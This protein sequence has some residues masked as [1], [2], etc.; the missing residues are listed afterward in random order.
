MATSVTQSLFGMTPQ[1]IQAQRAAELNQQAMQF[2][3]LSPMQQAQMGMFRAGSQLGT[4]V[5]GAMGYED[6]EIAQ[7]R[8]AQGLLGG[9]DMGDPEA[10]R[11]AARNTNDPRVKAFLVDRAL[12][13]EKTQADIGRLNALAQGGGKTGVGTGPERM[14]K[15]IADVDARLAEGKPVSDL[16]LRT[17]DNFRTV[18]SSVKTYQLTD[19]TIIRIPIK[20]FSA[21]Q[22]AEAEGA[23]EIPSG[24]APQA[25]Q[26]GQ[27]Q[28]R[29]STQATGGAQVIETPVS[30]QA[31]TKELTGL[32]NNID[33]IQSDLTNIDEAIGMVNAFST[34]PIGAVLSLGPTDAR[35]LR[36]LVEGIDAAKVFNELQKL[37]DGAAS[38]A[39][40]LGQVTEREISLLMNRL[41]VLDPNGRQEDLIKD[42]QYISDSWKSIQDRIKG[43]LEGKQPA[44]PASASPA[45]RT[46][47]QQASSVDNAS[48]IDR[49]MAD[50]RNAGKSRA[51]VEAAL[52]KRGLIK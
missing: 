18:L 42:L 5:A 47:P 3:Q 22:Q 4:G 13:I 34:G 32:Q 51:Q 17:A 30:I 27:P 35:R 29:P 11:E 41:R 6:P 31:K 40:G 44:R 33:T 36:R 48:V 21:Q 24:V 50:P 10:L 43:E 9:T 19:G 39:S 15:Y 2:A 45:P 49:V 8:A 16:E 26:T 20:D 25:P 7:A 1:A 37:R 52:R 46:A 14:A 28:P 12:E 23:I 38:G